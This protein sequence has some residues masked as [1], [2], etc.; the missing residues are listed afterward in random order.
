MRWIKHLT[1]THLDE[2]VSAFI[3]QWGL[4]LYG[5]YWLIMEILG[6]AMD[7]SD[8]YEVTHSL[9]QWSHLCCCHPNKFLKHLGNLGGVSISAVGVTA[10]V[11]MQVPP[12]V[13]VTWRE[14]RITV[15]C[16]NLLELRDEYSKKSGH[17]QDKVRTKKQNIHSQAEVDKGAG[18]KMLPPRAALRS[19]ILEFPNDPPP[20]D[21]AL[22]LDEF[23]EERWA[24]H[25]A[26]KRRDRVLAEG[27]ILDIPGIETLPVQKGFREG[28]ESYIASEDWQWRDGVKAQTLADFA[29]DGNWKYPAPKPPASEQSD[30]L[31]VAEAVIAEGRRYK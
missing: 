11:P 6:E 10:R 1:R 21:G 4:E 13:T 8:R 19:N 23:I 25:P 24:R 27:A 17:Y 30:T 3:A 14:G 9:S 7:E 31:A 20:V 26:V 28:H 15:G 18:A 2:A 22:P 29:K 5:F 16:R 12:V